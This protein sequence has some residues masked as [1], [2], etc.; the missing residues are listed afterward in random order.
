MAGALSWL[1]ER[2]IRRVA[3]VGSS[4]GGAI[5]IASVVT[6]GD[7]SLA[8]ADHDPFGP[9]ATV[10]APRPR[11]VAIV[12]ES[13]PPDFRIPIAN[14][15]GVPI[16]GLLRRAIAGRMFE[17]ASRQVGGD[18]RALE[19]DRV[20]GLVEPV[21]LLLIHGAAD[22]TVPPGRWTAPRRPCWPLGGTLDVPGADHSEAR[23]AAPEEWDDR[24]SRFLRQ[25]FIDAREAAPIIAPPVDPADAPGARGLEGD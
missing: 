6:L 19:P 8:A 9:A 24:V 23:A 12:A 5:A 11:I 25:A 1:G 22:R 15:M 13:V 3:L 4:M 21:P 14:R 20:I 7:G 16:G 10:D 18:L 2:G 17:S